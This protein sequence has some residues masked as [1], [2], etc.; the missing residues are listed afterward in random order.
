MDRAGLKETKESRDAG[1]MRVRVNA[2]IPSWMTFSCVSIK[3]GCNDT[4]ECCQDGT[5][6]DGGRH[7][8][9]G[10]DSEDPTLVGGEGDSRVRNFTKL[11]G[12]V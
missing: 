7:T 2:P 12:A 9:I 11:A 3:E 6:A 4:S 1:R 8:A 10:L 5:P